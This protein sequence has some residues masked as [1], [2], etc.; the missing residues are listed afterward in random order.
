MDINTIQTNVTDH[1]IVM[2]LSQHNFSD[3][4]YTQAKHF[5][6]LIVSL[7]FS[8]N[9]EGITSFQQVEEAR[10]MLLAHLKECL[11]RETTALGVVHRLHVE[12]LSRRISHWGTLCYEAENSR[13]LSQEQYVTY[14]IIRY[15]VII[16]ITHSF[17]QTA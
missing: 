9:S 3:D 7:W 11:Q 17:F 2:L 8:V 1:L 12:W 16:I 13:T 4:L 14:P 6:R 15:Y 5:L 10:D